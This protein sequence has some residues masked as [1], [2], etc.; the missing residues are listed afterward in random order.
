MLPKKTRGETV[1]L[2]LTLRFGNE[3]SLRDQSRA[4]A[5]IPALL[6]AGT[7]N[8]D[9]QALQARMTELGIEISPGG[10][11]GRRGR[12]G[13]GGGMGGDGGA[14]S[15]SIN[16]KRSSL[17]EGI[18]LLGEILRKP[19]FPED[20]FQQMKT[21]MIDM[22]KSMKSQPQ[23]LAANEMSR[24]MSQ[25]PPG[26]VRYVPTLD[27]T[28]EQLESMT[29][30]QVKQVYRQQLSAATGEIAVVG[31]FDPLDV[32]NAL[33]EILDDWKS[34][35][36]Y[37]TIQR[38]AR[39]DLKGDRLDIHTPDMANAVF[40]AGLAFPLNDKD[41][42]AEALRLGNFILGGGTLS[43][44]LGDRIRQQ[45]GLSYGVSSSVA[46]PGEGND[47]RF[48]INAITN[49][50]NMDAVEKAAMEELT[51]FIQEGPTTEEVATAITAWLESQKVARSR[52]GSIAGQIKENLYLGRTFRF[53]AERESRIAQLTADQIKAAF[54][55][56]VDPA[57]L[58]IIRAGDFQK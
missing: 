34:D 14:L 39:S 32:M 19:A 38:E 11:G 31:E 43:S 27:E 40:A 48:S 6:M 21:R 22:M 18:Q 15:F 9:R 4:A 20:D 2:S 54:Q 46:I 30:E 35:V 1:N 37:A 51:R 36:A 25:Y 3:M 33:G 49:P 23:M 10:G 17:A 42:D 58:V 44:R 52:D 7:E 26:D 12:R 8:L 16:A 24:S 5:M 45:E 41:P 28:I 29:L 47:A 56:H 50:E 13:G 53:T 55:K 57:R